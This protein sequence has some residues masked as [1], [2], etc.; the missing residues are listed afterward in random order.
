MPGQQAVDKELTKKAVGILK[1]ARYGGVRT[2]G[3]GESGGDFIITAV[4]AAAS[5]CLAKGPVIQ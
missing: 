3:S 2:G 1:N 5:V 4:R